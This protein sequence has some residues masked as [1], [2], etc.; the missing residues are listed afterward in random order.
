MIQLVCILTIFSLCM[1]M[2]FIE[3]ATVLTDG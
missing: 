2:G 3:N 1:I